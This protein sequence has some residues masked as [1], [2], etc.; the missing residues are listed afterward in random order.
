M[1]PDTVLLQYEL[2]QRR[3]F[4]WIVTRNSIRAVELAPRD[5]IETA[6]RNALASLQTSEF[7]PARRNAALQ[8][9]S[10]Q[11]LAPVAQLL[12]G[13]RVLVAADGAL[14]YVPFSVLPV[15]RDGARMAL[16]T[17]HEV[18]SV[19]SMSALAAQR[20][21]RSAES[22]SKTLAVFA[23]PVFDRT[24]GRLTRPAA[25]TAAEPRD[26]LMTR[27]SFELRRLPYSGREARDIAA[28]V[29][30]GARLVSEGFSASRNEVLHTDLKQ[31][32]YVHFATHG[33]VDS[34]YPALSALALSQFDREGNSLPGYLRLDDIYA[35]D[36][37]ADLV[38]LSACDTALGR[39]IRGEGLV[40]L[41]QA[42]LYAGTKGLVLSLWQVSDAATAVLMARFYEHM[43]KEGAPPAQALRAAQLSMA[44]ESR[45]ADPYYWG[46]FIL[47]GDV[48]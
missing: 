42:F 35:L 18:I 36:L 44:A 47:L 30:E 21:R 46:A 17:T 22:P 2:G 39:E 15:M 45:W 29:P 6:A 41:T 34:R 19:P 31:Y 27:S 25:T 1:D 13:D 11:V 10:D 23:D 7:A 12:E 5:A 32:R 24:D 4:V 33:L 28:L 9:V 38:V 16:I 14:H 26:E 3:S 8:A 20:A 48:R 43:I 40:G 37:N